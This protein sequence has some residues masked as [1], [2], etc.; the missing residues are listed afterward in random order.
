[1]MGFEAVPIIIPTAM[2]THAAIMMME[3]SPAILN[4]FEYFWMYD[5]GM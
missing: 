5:I 4:A 1:M 3:S 2:P